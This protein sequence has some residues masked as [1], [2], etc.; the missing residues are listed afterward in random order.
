[1]STSPL[2]RR[3]LGITERGPNTRIPQPCIRGCVDQP[4]FQELYCW[5]GV[6]ALPTKETPHVSDPL[7]VLLDSPKTHTHWATDSQ[8]TAAKPRG[9]APAAVHEPCWELFGV[10]A[11]GGAES[12]R[13]KAKQKRTKGGFNRYMGG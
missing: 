10:R 3:V 5:K 9:P 4:S 7:D 12:G 6:Y 1:M 8:A 11:Y 13:T 2:H